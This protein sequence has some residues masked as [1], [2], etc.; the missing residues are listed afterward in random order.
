MASWCYERLFYSCTPLVSVMV[1]PYPEERLEEPGGQLEMP[2]EW[3]FSSNY[4]QSCLELGP[5]PRGPAGQWAS[6]EELAVPGGPACCAGCSPSLSGI[7][8]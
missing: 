5:A 3:G 7:S 6:E 1:F 4:R 8:C 2:P